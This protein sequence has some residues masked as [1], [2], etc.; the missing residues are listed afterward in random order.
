MHR[1]IATVKTTPPYLAG[2]AF[3]YLWDYL[4]HAVAVLPDGTIWKIVTLVTAIILWRYLEKPAVQRGAVVGIGV[5]SIVGSALIIAPGTPV[6]V[7]YAGVIMV[8]ACSALFLLLWCSIYARVPLL[9]AAVAFGEMQIASFG[10]CLITMVLPKSSYPGLALVVVLFSCTA[11]FAAHRTCET[12]VLGKPTKPSPASSAKPMR[13][14][15]LV[16]IFLCAFACGVCRFS[17]PLIANGTAFGLCGVILLTLI[18]TSRHVGLYRTIQLA[19]PLLIGGLVIAALVGQSL[20]PLSAVVSN[21]GYALMTA[22]F[23]LVLADRS[24]RL[25]TP[26]LPTLGVMRLLLMAGQF[27][28]SNSAAMVQAYLPQN[29]S[30]TLLA[31]MVVVVALSCM[32]WYFDDDI[33]TK[34]DTSFIAAGAAADSQ[35]TEPA[36]ATLGALKQQITANIEE[37]AVTYDLTK[38]EME[39]ANYLALGW[40]VPRIEQELVLSNST[41]KTHVKH[42]YSKLG[43]HSR[44]ELK[45]IIGADLL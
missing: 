20:F 45:I 30:A 15:M 2:A 12:H 38:R 24:F 42:L 25:G 13:P 33:P 39:I 35:P 29:A 8:N 41:V 23:T 40:S 1:L 44:D 27:A 10:L 28:G 17:S 11:F 3:L 5:I 34:E 7:L 32:A 14:L 31:L 16:A 37:L 21:T 9:N 6:A 18:L 22:V 26:A 4:L 19:M 43:I 36:T